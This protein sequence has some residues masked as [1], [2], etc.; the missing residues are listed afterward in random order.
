MRLTSRPRSRADIFPQALAA[1][2]H[3]DM[4]QG[5][6]CGAC[7]GTGEAPAV[8]SYKCERCHVGR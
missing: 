7:H 4:N 8:H 3:A 2:T 5:K 1:F 6:F